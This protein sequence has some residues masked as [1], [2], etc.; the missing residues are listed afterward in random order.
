MDTPDQLAPHA[1]P[2][3]AD[4]L[5]INQRIPEKFH[6]YGEGQQ[7]DLEQSAGKMADAYGHLAQRLGTTE[8]PPESASQYQLNG[9]AFGE[10]FD[11]QDFMSN[12]STQEF[13]TKMH[14]KGLNNSQ[15]QEVLEFGLKE[16]APQ[17]MQGNQI[18]DQE[19]CVSELRQ[20]WPKPHDYEMHMNDAGRALR[21]LPDGLREVAS[22]ALGNNPSFV[23]I[24]A[25]FGREMAEDTSAKDT[26]S[27]A[28]LDQKSVETLQLSEAYKNPNHP[29]HERV[30][31]QVS[32]WYASK[33]PG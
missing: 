20:A 25:L 19:E 13:L 17:L 18:L 22:G 32:N 7:F 6:V 33:Y 30:S 10:G 8:L 28:G 21:S 29:D 11:V 26:I 16:W 5:P 27:I 24:M 23:K 4:P 9:E 3:A 1:E 14:A 2:V 12:E 31:K 15:V